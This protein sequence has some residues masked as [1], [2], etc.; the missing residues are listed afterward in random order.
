MAAAF[1]LLG[2]TAN[3]QLFDGYTKWPR[4][5]HT[6]KRVKAGYG[7]SYGQVGVNGELGTKIFSGTAGLGLVTGNDL[8][9]TV[10]F[11]VGTRLYMMAEEKQGRVRASAHYGVNGV[12]KEDN[13]QRTA[14]GLAF[15]IGFEHRITQN[16]VYD[17]DLLVPINSTNSARPQ[18]AQLESTAIPSIGIGIFFNSPD[19]R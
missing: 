16:V 12:F 10:G 9:P 4:P 13:R 18:N 7:L 15:G 2:V 6:W 19:L 11:T 14:I 17:M 8:T 1:L 5:K 3:A